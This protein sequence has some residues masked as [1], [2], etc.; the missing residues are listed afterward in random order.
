M[1]YIVIELHCNPWPESARNAFMCVD[2]N[3]CRT[4]VTLLDYILSFRPQ[5]L[6]FVYCMY[7]CMR[8]FVYVCIHTY[9]L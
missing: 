6:N 7:A 3:V 1:S 2:P 8:T 5:T 4:R 9:C